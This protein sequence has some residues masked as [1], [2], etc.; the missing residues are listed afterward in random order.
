MPFTP[1][2][3]T[4]TNLAVFNTFTVPSYYTSVKGITAGYYGPLLIN[5]S[6]QSAS[7]V[8]NGSKIIL[9]LPSGF[10]P[11][12]NALGL[13]ISCKLNSVPQPCTYV[14][15]PTFIITITKTNSSFTTSNNVINITTN[16]QNSNGVF[17]PSTVG[18]YLLQL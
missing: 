9:T 1:T 4:N 2:P 17:Y 12:G 15:S 11:A 6:P 7:T 14:I 16:Y 5:F 3:L 10:Y 18:R 13:P 8:I